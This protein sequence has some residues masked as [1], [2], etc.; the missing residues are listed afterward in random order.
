LPAEPAF[1]ADFARHARHLAGEAVELVN[2]GV[3]RF[4]QL[5]DLAAHVDRNLARQVAPGDRRGNFGNVAHLGGQIAGHRVDAIGQVLPGTGDAGDLRLT[6]EL[7]LG[8][9][10]TRDA[11]DFGGESVELIDHGVERVFQLE[12]LTTHVDGNLARQVAPRHGG[13]DFGDVA[14]LPRKVRGH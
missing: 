13:G 6:A 3:Q 9:D 12:N 7:A 14:D 10:L 4:L 5:K 11:R 1:G 2:H 8:A